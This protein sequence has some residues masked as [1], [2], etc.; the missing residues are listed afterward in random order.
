M[1]D[2]RAPPDSF[3]RIWDIPW[4]FGSGT[5]ASKSNWAKASLIWVLIVI[6]F[7]ILL[8]VLL[9]GFALLSSMQ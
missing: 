4:A 2:N 3:N 6:A 7:Y 5:P 9:G 8:F 1:K